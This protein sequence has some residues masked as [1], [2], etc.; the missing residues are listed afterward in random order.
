MIL[1]E[2]INYT[3]NISVEG[4]DEIDILTTPTVDGETNND[5]A[6][7]IKPAA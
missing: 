5:I 3:F 1:V 7:E 4:L 6:F 2:G